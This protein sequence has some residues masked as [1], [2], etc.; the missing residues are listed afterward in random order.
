VTLRTIVVGVDG[1]AGAAEALRWA[2]DLA[3]QTGAHLVAVHAFEPLA[4]I[5]RAEP[6]LDFVRLADEVG[7]RLAQEWCSGIEASG[8]EL[9]TVVID[10]EPTIALTQAAEQ[11]EADLVV[12]GTRGLGRIK[13]IVL[14]SVARKLPE[15]AGRPVTIIPPPGAEPSETAPKPAG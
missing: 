2:A 6:P 4:W 5:G 7:R 9:S 14:G 10:D 15:V 3:R 12:V 1:S 11:H 13:R 8:V